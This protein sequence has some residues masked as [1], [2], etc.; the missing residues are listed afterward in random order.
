MSSPTITVERIPQSHIPKW[1]PEGSLLK[2][3][4]PANLSSTHRQQR[5][6]TWSP[7]TQDYL[8]K[9]SPSRNSQ[10]HGLLGLISMRA[11]C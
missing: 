9:H 1:L 3:H 7:T 2:P 5:T 6:V 10:P 11:Q 8:I 4:P